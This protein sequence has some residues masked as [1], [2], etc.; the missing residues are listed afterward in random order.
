MSNV[1]FHSA[2]GIGRICISHPPLN[3]FSHSLMTGLSAALAQFEADASLPLL[4]IYCEG[5]SFVAGA[6]IAEFNNPAFSAEAI[7]ALLNRIEAQTRPV[8]VALHGTVLGAGMELALACH[9]RVAQRGSKL[10]LP[11]VKLGIL[12]G[13]GGTQR[14][15]RLVGA[16]LALDMMLSGRPVPAQEALASGIV[17][18]VEEGDP[19]AFGLAF[20]RQLLASGGQPRRLSA[21]PAPPGEHSQAI[22][23]ALEAAR[24]S[25]Q[26]P[27]KEAIVLCVQQALTADFASGARAEA[28]AFNRLLPSAQSRALRHLF[29]A[30]RR[31]RQIPGLERQVPASKVE[32]VG[33]LGAGTMGSG[34]AMCF[35]N[36]GIRTVL[37]DAAAAGLERGLQLI[38]STY[39]AQVAK[40]RM[41]AEQASARLA[42]LTTSLDDQALAPC[43]LVIEA[44]FED[45]ALKLQVCR[46]LGEVC[47]PGAIIASNTSTL[48]VD[49]LAQATGRPADVVGMHFFSPANIMRLLE[50]VR[51]A[52]T[53]PQVLKTVIDLAGKIG[54]TPVV[55][56]V[57]F[58]FIGNRMAEVYL[59]EAEFL[60][61]EGASPAQIDEAV[62]ALGL[63]MGPCR[64]LDM[65]GLDVGAKTVIECDKAGGLPP[66][67]SYRA[68]VRKMFELGRFGQKTSL[69]YYRY[70]GRQALPDP[71]AGRIAAELAQAHGI[72]QRSDIAAQEI[73]ER[74]LY[75]MVN[76]GCK[77]LDEGI[78]YRAS[79]ID[80]VWAA[81]YGFP[82]FR[83]GPMFM[84]EQIGL[85]QIVERL[86]HQATTRGNRYGYWTVSPL[87][88]R[89][90]AQR[91]GFDSLQAA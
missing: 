65:A 68:V 80:V 32:Q 15:P 49:A 41:G 34:I 58:G 5:P 50:V 83:G 78:A 46:R 20:G 56:G 63:A 33:I 64:M 29:F 38:R 6:D 30:Q 36:A 44:V 48:D 43:D 17:D 12:P 37:V 39:E 55:S 79:D 91:Q 74:L 81:G 2:D 21:Q 76:E 69:G 7:N 16:A 75:S 51:G 45:M 19:L 89:L 4:L 67:A 87:L 71:E 62:Q 3:L 23:S 27:A 85:A 57:C 86:E 66:D 84:A 47:K 72:A 22:A 9:Y 40:G 24:K 35:L 52:Q 14:L 1:T 25:P 90:A 13:A 8:V 31:S 70:E 10:G 77:I 88:Q 26:Y 11:E 59:R 61:M 73:V 53:A 60:L 28:E 42:L 18:A 54:K 82:D